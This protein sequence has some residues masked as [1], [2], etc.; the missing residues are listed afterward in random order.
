[1]S[2]VVVSARRNEVSGTPFLVA[3]VI[4]TH[5]AGE[6][7]ERDKLVKR[8]SDSLPL[9]QYIRPAVVTEVPYFATNSSGKLDRKTINT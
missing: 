6:E 7:A 1:M 9:P 3:Y 4:L 5:E 2:Q 8:L